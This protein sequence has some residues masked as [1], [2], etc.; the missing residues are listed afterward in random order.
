MQEKF[1]IF[2]FL[3]NMSLDL[4]EKSDKE[5]EMLLAEKR[6]LLS[7]LKFKAATGSLKNVREIRAVRKNIARI[8][9]ALRCIG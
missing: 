5:L 3:K 6:E 7:K 4:K 2:N 9:T 8:L 1:L